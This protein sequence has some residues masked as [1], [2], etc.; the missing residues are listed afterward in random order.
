[1]DLLAFAERFCEPV[2]A[3]DVL[4]D[5]I[6]EIGVYRDL[7]LERNVNGLCGWAKCGAPVRSQ[8]DEKTLI[9]CSHDCQF[10]SQQF[11]ASLVPP[12]AGPIG[13]VVE[14]FQ[15]QRPPKPLKRT[16]ADEIDGFRVRVGPYRVALNEIETWFGGFR[17]LSFTG[18]SPAQAEVFAC[19][20]ASLKEIGAE[21]KRSH[22]GISQFF[23]NINVA[24][25]KVLTESPKPL[26]MAFAF[27]VYEYATRAEVRPALTAFEIPDSLYSDLWR[28]V[29][30]TDESD[31]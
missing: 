1:M 22:V 20:N 6:L 18:M 16:A 21:L 12:Q 29:C 10:N 14:R 9:F 13:A 3:D 31:Y 7:V 2:V 4:C 11:G 5:P 30:Q 24:D 17:V 19:V 26:R 15:E 23:V 25:P 27:A 28:I 8:P